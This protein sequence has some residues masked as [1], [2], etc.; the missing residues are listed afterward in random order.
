MIVVIKG[1]SIGAK[2]RLLLIL[3]TS[4]IFS[5]VAAQ[6]LIRTIG[7]H[8]EKGSNAKVDNY[9]SKNQGLQQGVCI[10]GYPALQDGRCAPFEFAHSDKIKQGR[11]GKNRE[12]E[13]DPQKHS[14]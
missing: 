11:M 10:V 7:Q 13:N 14:G 2:T 3:C 8:Y 5:I 12:T 9:S 4:V 6:N 1:I